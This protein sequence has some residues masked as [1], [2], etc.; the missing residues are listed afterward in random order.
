MIYENTDFPFDEIKD[1]G[2][3][4]F[5]NVDQAIKQTGLSD[6][7][8]WSVVSDDHMDKDGWMVYIFGPAHHYCNVIGY[9]ATKEPHDG[10]TYYIEEVDFT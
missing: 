9:V 3:D 5:Y 8:I 2:G 7:N 6:N 4:Y 1:S 10:E